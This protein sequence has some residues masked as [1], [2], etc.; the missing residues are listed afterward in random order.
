MCVRYL[1]LAA[2]VV[3]A[4]LGGAAQ[5]GPPFL[6]DDPEPV[7]LRHWE[8]YAAS[9]WS[10]DRHGASGTLPHVEVNYGALPGLQLHL[11]VPAVLSMP[12]RSPGQTSPREYGLGDI[13][14]GAKFR[15]VE[16]TKTHPQVGIFPVVTLPSGDAARGLGTGRAQGLLPI[17]IQKSFGPWTS[18]GG[19]GIR[20]AAASQATVLGWLLQ[21]QLSSKV[22]L[23]GEIYLTGPLAGE[24]AQEQL[25][26]G[27]IV[28]F[29]E[30][31]H[32]LISAG[33][34][35]GNATRMQAYA[36]YQITTD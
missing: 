14:L 15:F 7:A 6:T 33:P 8:L 22:T 25:N 9:Q 23:G 27:L 2:G 26:V 29:S 4:L 28:N 10:W 24:A 3:M 30:V 34:S 11:I 36:A 16:E 19:G 32:L 20:F 31:R 17:W 5:A 13:E 18:Y 12:A 21:R 35:F 1:A